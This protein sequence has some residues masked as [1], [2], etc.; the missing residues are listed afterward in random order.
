VEEEFVSPPERGRVFR[1]ERRVHLGDVDREARLR[2]AALARYLQDVATDDADDSGLDRHRGV[3]VVRRMAIA[4]FGIPRYHDE[5]E[6]LTFCS[7]T[8]PA[9]AE[10]RTTMAAEGRVLA[11]CAAIW[12]YLD[13]A[14]G[15]PQ[16]LDP[17]FFDLYGVA[18]QDRRV[19]GRLRH[20][21]PAPALGSRPWALRD[22][23]FDVLDHVN[24]ARA[25][26]AIEDELVE[27]LGPHRVETVTV[28]FRGALERG[29]DVELVSE[30]RPL[31]GPAQQVTAWL[32]TRGEVRVSA[33]AVARTDG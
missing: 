4:V 15:R 19:H 8:G 5:V 12:V 26:E 18:A 17:A 9:W 23:D 2:L 24:N 33:V 32:V 29:D 3:W 27:R 1:G 13:A 6:L 20:P 21:R 11:E 28:E 16:A 10:R 22:S 14:G 31:E 30:V 7:G 25:F